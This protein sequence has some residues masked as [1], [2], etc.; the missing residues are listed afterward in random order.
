MK[1][2]YDLIGKS[3]INKHNISLDLY[4]LNSKEYYLVINNNLENDFSKLSKYKIKDNE[5]LIKQITSNFNFEVR[6]CS[7]LLIFN[8]ALLQMYEVKRKMYF[9]KITLRSLKY[10]KSKRNKDLNNINPYDESCFINLQ[11][12]LEVM[13]LLINY[14]IKNRLITTFKLIEL[15]SL[16]NEANF[17]YENA[18][19]PSSTNINVETN[20]I[21][22]YGHIFNIKNFINLK[23][24]IASINL[25]TFKG[26]IIKE[27]VTLYKDLNTNYYFILDKDYDD[28]LIKGRALCYQINLVT[29]L[30]SLNKIDD[31]NIKVRSIKDLLPFEFLSLLG[32]DTS[33]LRFLSSKQRETILLTA[34]KNNIFNKHSL[35]IYLNQCLNEKRDIYSK[36][37]I[38]NRLTSDLNFIKNIDE[39]NLEPIL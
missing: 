35:T 7:I 16:Y 4:L 5:D 11:Q 37:K 2:R 38:V 8:K 28:L 17:K 10:M 21:L 25:I 39:S 13:K 6:P 22:I 23:F 18:K 15:A 26:E 3:S 29:Y 9:K 19:S 20:D 24:V 14:L 27:K 1:D 33:S 31:K 12:L 30:S 34:I 36:G 32:Y